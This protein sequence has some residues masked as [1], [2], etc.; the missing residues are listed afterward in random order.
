MVFDQVRVEPGFDMREQA[1]I[2]L[3]MWLQIG[4]EVEDRDAVTLA[5]FFVRIE[6]QGNVVVA[7]EAYDLDLLK[8]AN[9][10]LDPFACLEHVTQDHETLGSMLLKH[11]DGLLQV[12]GVLMDVG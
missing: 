7:P 11:G 6:A 3:Q 1:T 10:L 9:G 8:Q 5:H 4:H 12:P 2:D